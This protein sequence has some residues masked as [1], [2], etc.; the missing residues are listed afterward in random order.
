MFILYSGQFHTLKLNI[1]AVCI[2]DTKVINL[3]VSGGYGRVLNLQKA[4]PPKKKIQTKYKQNFR[5]EKT[6]RHR[7][8]C[9]GT[10]WM[11]GEHFGANLKFA[12]NH[13]L[14]MT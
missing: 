3:M 1:R 14:F 2:C 8:R 5:V 4:P 11:S 7:R 9:G 6:R 12:T 10:F 13:A